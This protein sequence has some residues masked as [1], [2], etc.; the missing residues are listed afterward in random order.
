M[1]INQ[2]HLFEELDG[3]KCSIVE[4]NCSPERAE[5]L[6][7][8]LEVNRYTVVVAATPIKAAP[9]PPVT[10]DA[11]PPPPPPPPPPTT[12][13]V[14]VTDLTFNPTNA[15]FGRLLRT[16]DGHLITMNYWKQKD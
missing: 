8:L 10:A 9:A 6:K 1:A 13:I 5:F 7:N 16:A 14:G 4:K 11:P 15:I 3:V 2:N 12:F